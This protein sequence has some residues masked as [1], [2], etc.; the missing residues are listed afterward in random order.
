MAHCPR[1]IACSLAHDYEALLGDLEVLSRGGAV[2]YPK[3]LAIAARQATSTDARVARRAYEHRGQRSRRARRSRER[4][5]LRRV[6]P[7]SLRRSRARA[8]L[9]AAQGRGRRGRAP[10]RRRVAGGGGAGAGRGARAQGAAA[11]A[12]LDRASQ[13]DPARVAAHDP[14]HGRAHVGQGRRE[15]V[16]RPHAGRE[17]QHRRERA[18]GRVRGARRDSATRRFWRERCR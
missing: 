3:T 14:A 12:A 11:R 16:R 17:R 10:S 8:G 7:A 9:A 4:T 6:D 2:G 5:A 13:H 1:P 15:A 18:R